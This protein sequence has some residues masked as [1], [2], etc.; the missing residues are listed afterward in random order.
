[1]AKVKFD[2]SKISVDEFAEAVEKE[3]GCKVT[4]K[5]IEK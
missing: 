4:D 5:K 2:G 3:T 1:M